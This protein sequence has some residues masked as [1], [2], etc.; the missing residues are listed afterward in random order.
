MIS[1]GKIYTPSQR[2]I[3]EDPKNEPDGL[4]WARINS[5]GIHEKQAAVKWDKF[6]LNTKATEMLEKVQ[7]YEFDIFVINKETEGNEMVVLSLYLFDKHNLF[8]ILS[9]NPKTFEIFISSIQ[10]GYNDIAYH[11]KI[12][13]MDVGRLTYYYATT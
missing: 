7:D 9:I 6:N 12:H 13:G 8:D 3:A 5:N 11:N 2:K 4:L 1:S 10:E